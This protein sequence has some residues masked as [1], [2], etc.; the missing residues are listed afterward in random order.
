MAKTVII[1]DNVHKMVESKIKEI[2][3]RHG[4]ELQFRDL[5][6]KVIEKN[7]DKFEINT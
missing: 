1:Y 3:E 4:F 5:I 7:I 2:K 6:N